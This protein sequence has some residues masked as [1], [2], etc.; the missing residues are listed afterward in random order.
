[1]RFVEAA[2]AAVAQ[3]KIMQTGHGNTPRLW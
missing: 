3:N 1:V 2:V